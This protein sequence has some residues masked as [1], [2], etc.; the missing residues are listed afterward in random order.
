MRGSDEL[1]RRF[2]GPAANPHLVPMLIAIGLWGLRKA[3]S[4]EVHVHEHFHDGSLHQ[5]IHIHHGH[6]DGSV[7]G[8]QSHAH[9]HAALAA[10]L[11]H[12]LAGGAHF[13]GVLPALAMPTRAAAALYILAFAMGTVVAMTGFS[14]A[15]GALGSR[16]IWFGVNGF[17]GAMSVCSIVAIAVGI[18]WLAA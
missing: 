18:Y 14:S 9:S 1:H 10:G 17:R 6:A 15:I 12:G 16:M 13:L 5:H 4:V 11:L 2:A 8:V 3:L 7:S